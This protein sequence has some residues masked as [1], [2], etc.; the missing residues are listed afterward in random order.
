MQKEQFIKVIKNAVDKMAE[1]VVFDTKKHQY[2]RKSDGVILQG[3]STV[4]NIVPKSWLSAWGGKECSKF[5]GFTD[6]PDNKEDIEKAE[7]MLEKIKGMDLEQYLALLKQAKGGAFRKSKDAMA[8]GTK[9]HKI[10]ED[11]I[12][13]KIEGIEPPELPLEDSM[14]LRP[15]NQFIEWEEKNVEYWI[16]SEALVASPDQ[17][18]AGTMDG[19]ALMKSGK[20]A[21]IDFKFASVISE[22]SILQVA[23]YQQCFENVGIDVD[24]RIIIRLPKT[25][26]KDE[27][28]KKT[29]TYSKV[30]NDLEVKILDEGYEEDRDV[31][32]ACLPLKSW[33]N[34]I[35]K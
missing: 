24:Q 8:D 26:E 2:S 35:T 16:L 14:L 34:R 32:L 33:I 20:L 5:L 29:R 4:S 28:D 30:A 31:F 3:V 13:A 9:G 15:I 22:D 27:Y 12:K 21:V 17:F 6:Y 23:G 7:K 18:Y 11:W 19:L 10:L 1:E 25:L